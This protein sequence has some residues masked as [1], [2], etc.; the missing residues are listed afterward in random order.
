MSVHLANRDLLAE[1]LRCAG[2][3]LRHDAFVYF[4]E[5]RPPAIEKL[6]A[7][8]GTIDR[9]LWNTRL[10]ELA[11][12]LDQGAFQKHHFRWVEFLAHSVDIPQSMGLI[13]AAQ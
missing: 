12:C 6:L 3:L 9:A 2:L 4:D 10:D 13:R 11:A 5:E 8:D 1:W 7:A